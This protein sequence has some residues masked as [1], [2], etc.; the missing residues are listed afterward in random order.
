[1]CV[2]SELNAIPKDDPLG[3]RKD[4]A[5]LLSAAD[6]FL[7]TSISEGIPLTAIE[8]MNAGLPVVATRVGG[9][10]EIVV[11]GRTGVLA[12]SRD[13]EELADCILRL[14]AD[15]ALRAAMGRAGRERARAVFSQ[16]RMHQ[17]YL[18]LYQEMLDE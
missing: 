1:M 3:L 11:Q 9:L 5:R 16:S 14:A 8:A 17:Q 2:P 10:P 18:E 15:P 6:V 7:L 4:I 13:D 12:P